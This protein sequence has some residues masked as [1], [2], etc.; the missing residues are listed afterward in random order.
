M[1]WPI[2]RPMVFELFRE[3]VCRLW[4]IVGQSLDELQAGERV[5][6]TLTST[7]RWI[8]CCGRVQKRMIRGHQVDSNGASVAQVGTLNARR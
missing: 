1:A 8:L 7:I 4:Q 3:E 5:A 6:V 2:K